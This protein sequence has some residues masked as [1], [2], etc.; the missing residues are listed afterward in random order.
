MDTS[1]LN[2]FLLLP[3]RSAAEATGATKVISPLKARSGTV[4]IRTCTNRPGFTWLM[5]DS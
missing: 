4:S 2:T 1:H 3:Q 5:R